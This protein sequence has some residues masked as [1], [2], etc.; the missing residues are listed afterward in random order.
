ML[1]YEIQISF[2][3][4]DYKSKLLGRP[5]NTHHI[6]VH[7]T[8]QLLTSDDISLELLSRSCNFAIC[9]WSFAWISDGLRYND[10]LVL[11]LKVDVARIQLGIVNVWKEVT[12]CILR[13]TEAI[14]GQ[15]AIIIKSTAI[16]KW[17]YM[18]YNPAADIWAAVDYYFFNCLPSTPPS[19]KFELSVDFDLASYSQFERKR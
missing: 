2:V 5:T 3:W 11:V 9:S 6:Y 13:K 15:T 16:V 14:G 12:N 10:V 19:F 8:C 18:K 17:Y 1:L 7:I 4:E